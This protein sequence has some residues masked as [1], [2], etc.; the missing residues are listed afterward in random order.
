MA[1]KESADRSVPHTRIDDE[2]WIWKVYEP[3]TKIGQGTFG[4]VFKVQHQGSKEYW[5]MKVVNKEKVGL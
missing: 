4:K 2:S 3:G 1:R 5:A